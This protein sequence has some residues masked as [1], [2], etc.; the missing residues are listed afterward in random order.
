MKRLVFTAV[1][2]ASATAVAEQPP[3]EHVLVSVP[4]HKKQAETVL[5]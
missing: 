5:D 4:L 3:M 2:L 1:A